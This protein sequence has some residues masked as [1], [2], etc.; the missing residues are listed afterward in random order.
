[1]ATAKP[2]LAPLSAPVRQVGEFVFF[3]G[4]VLWAGVRPPFRPGLIL[5]QMDFIGVG[6]LFIILL[7]GT[8]TGAVFTLQTVYAFSLFSMES[9]VGATVALALSRELSPVLAALMI[10]G[11]AGSAMATELGTMRV[12]EQVDALKSMAVNPIQYLVV[13]RVLAA[14]VMFP[15]M[16]MIFNMVGV[17]GS[18]TVAVEM[19]GIDP[20]AFI[21]KIRLMVLPHDVL[22]GLVKAGLFGALV[23]LVACHRGYNAEGGARGVGAATTRSVVIGSVGIMVLD[24]FLT[25]AMY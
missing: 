22:S 13:P 2:T 12:T 25:L 11:R 18:Y 14:L 19:Y 7:T 17:L 3:L 1:M 15:V 6:S 8:F 21:A 4:E 24:Y 5:Q 23:T 20:G 10:C 9:M 16:T